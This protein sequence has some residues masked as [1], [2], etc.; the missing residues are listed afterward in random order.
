MADSTTQNDALIEEEINKNDYLSKN[1]RGYITTAKEMMRRGMSAP[2]FLD[3]HK[4]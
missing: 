4:K 2:L 3:K 1:T